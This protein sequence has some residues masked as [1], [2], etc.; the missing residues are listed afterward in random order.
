MTSGIFHSD[1]FALPYL[2]FGTGEHILLAFHGFGRKK[3]DFL[4]FEKTLGQKYT[5]YTFDFFHHGESVYPDDRIS[6]NTLRPE[7]LS[8]I[9]E[10]FTSEKNIQNF[11]VMGYSMGG[12]ICLQILHSMPERIKEIYL[13][14]PDGIVT[15]FW[16]RFTSRNKLGN[17]LYR[18]ILN[19]PKPFFSIVKFLYKVRILNE[20][21]GKFVLKNLETKEKRQLVYNVWMTLRSIDP[22]P[23]FSA[24][25]IVENGIEC[26]LFFGKH[27]RVVKTATGKWF[28]K[29]IKQE[30]HFY[31]I[32]CGHNLF[33]ERTAQ[34]L[35]KVL[36][37][38]V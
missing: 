30:K 21:L 32:D 2:Q 16:Y 31:E 11:S 14:A 25:L 4:Y 29:K 24:N 23:K 3:E 26:Y 12:K 27:D 28:A 1:Q 6:K 33:T 9:I 20:K 38:V 34:T 8:A 37:S 19:N 13:L 15:N 17:N 5:V 36:G 7:E 18:K 35:E 10:K 22:D